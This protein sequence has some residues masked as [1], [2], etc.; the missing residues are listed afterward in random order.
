MRDIDKTYFKNAKD[1]IASLQNDK[2]LGGTSEEG[3]PT[4]A[5]LR[6]LG[7]ERVVESNSLM[8]EEDTFTINGKTVKPIYVKHLGRL[9]I[10]T[11]F[12]YLLEEVAQMGFKKVDFISSNPW[13][14]S[15]ELID[16]IARNNNVSR[17][18]H[19]A[20]QSG[21]NNVLKRMNRWYT[22]EEFILL[23]K[24]LKAK[25]PEIKITTDII[26][27]FCG[28]TDEEFENTFK[29]CTEVGFDWAYVARYSV[30]PMTAA[31]K[32]YIDNV[33]DATKKSRW[34]R[35]DALVNKPQLLHGTHQTI[36]Y[37]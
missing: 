8:R 18:L 34:E 36:A 22:R 14:F 20:V 4:G 7:E 37:I 23:T 10:P 12:P 30:R 16:V 25:I 19:I 31:T 33:S 24:K 17:K 15:D 32:V 21:D 13:D 5:S 1:S 35:L 26:V 3:L 9:R 28:E 29:L 6:G 2:E 11:I 27:G